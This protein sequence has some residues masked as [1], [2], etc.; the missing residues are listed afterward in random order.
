MPKQSLIVAVA[1]PFCVPGDVSGN[2]SR[3][4]PLLEE[5][6]AQQAKL[7]LFSETGVTGLDG[8]ARTW[9]VSV[10]LGD[11][12]CQ[13]LH[14]LA[15]RHDMVIA[16]GFLERHGE[17]IHNTHGVFF[18]DGELVVQRKARMFRYEEAIPDYEAVPEGFETFT[19]E[20]VLCAI[21]ICG[22]GGIA[23]RTERLT[24][25]GVQVHLTPTAG[26][27][28][29]EWGFR[30]AELD[31]PLRMAQYL[32][33]AESVVFSKEAI[34]Q[35]RERRM[36]LMTCN[37]MADNGVDCFHPGHSMIVDSTGEL[38]GLI[39]GDFVFEFLRPKVVCGEIHPH[40]PRA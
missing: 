25:A 38:V 33:R 13:R 31:D 40:Y 14:E 37:Q 20:G 27:G 19:V 15:R 36:C 10:T 32:E 1:Q 18:P 22:D 23:G 29:Y 30:S 35:S 3:M 39:P 24:E 4:E 12:T 5:A 6:A 16:A 34:R 2:I 17:K 26:C 21:T 8:T 28:P 9:N 11:A 7:I